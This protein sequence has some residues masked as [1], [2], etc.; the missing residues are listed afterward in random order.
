MRFE[1]LIPIIRK[2]QYE[3]AI[4]IPAGEGK[5]ATHLLL[6]HDEYRAF[7]AWCYDQ[8][9]IS[10]RDPSSSEIFCGL[11]VLSVNTR[12]F[13]AVTRPAIV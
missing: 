1:D 12:T 3:F 5:E 7:R 11:T 13:I 9:S 10:R 2:A 6:G 4:N 8:V